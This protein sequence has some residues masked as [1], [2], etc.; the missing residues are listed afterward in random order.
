[1]TYPLE[2]MI[3]ISHANTQLVRKLADIGYS[4]WEEA[5]PDGRPVH[6]RVCRSI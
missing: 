3:G 2:Q 4:N 1:M 6:E 5:R